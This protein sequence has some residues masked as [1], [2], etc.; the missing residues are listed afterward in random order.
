MNT[1]L[2]DPVIF[3]Y[4]RLEWCGFIDSFHTFLIS[5]NLLGVLCLLTQSRNFVNRVT[6]LFADKDAT[7]KRFGQFYCHIH[8]IY[9]TEKSIQINISLT[10]LKERKKEP[11]IWQCCSLNIFII[12][13]F[14]SLILMLCLNAY[15]H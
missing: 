7:Q 15:F 14:C 6:H 3:C 5:I 2:R 10:R 12:L 4:N 1:R 8:I 13:H 9:Y 11:Q